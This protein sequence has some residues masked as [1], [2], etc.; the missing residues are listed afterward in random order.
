MLTRNV[1]EGQ[2]RQ[3]AVGTLMVVKPT[4]E[5]VWS[6]QKRLLRSTDI[7]KGSQRD[8]QRRWGEAASEVERK[9]HGR[10]LGKGLT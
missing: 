8:R 10:S 7:L 5:Q 3:M 2:S 4:E 6:F 9:H 1:F